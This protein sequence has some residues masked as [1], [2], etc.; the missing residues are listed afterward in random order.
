MAKQLLSTSIFLCT[1]IFAINAQASIYEQTKC[2]NANVYEDIDCL[3]K[4]NA[5]FINHLNT[6]YKTLKA[7]K[8]SV[9][10]ASVSSAEYLRYFKESQTAWNQFTKANC[11]M[12]NL[13][14]ASLQ[15]AGV[16]LVNRAC[17]NEA[18]RSRVNE[19]NTWIIE[20]QK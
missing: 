15:G 6:I 5:Q 8:I 2:N 1:T 18:Y 20:L 19:L 4:E 16:G 9:D 17:W 11:Q 3:D 13:P 14:Y 10:E 7:E 12:L